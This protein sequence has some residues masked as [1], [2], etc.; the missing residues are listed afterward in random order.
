VEYPLLS[1]FDVWSPASYSEMISFCSIRLSG[2]L[3]F[4]IYR[5]WHGFTGFP[6]KGHVL[7]FVIL[8]SLGFN[9]YIDEFESVYFGSIER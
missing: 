4:N 8:H 5:A 1:H 3:R 7:I 9:C 6:E 2:K